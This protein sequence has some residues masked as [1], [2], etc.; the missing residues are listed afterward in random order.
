MDSSDR[1]ISNWQNSHHCDS[2][3]IEDRWHIFRRELVCRV[4]NQQTGLAHST[5]TNDHTSAEGAESAIVIISV[6][7]MLI[8]Q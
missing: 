2:I 7:D 8:C 6:V 1:D 5:I 3:V 4:A